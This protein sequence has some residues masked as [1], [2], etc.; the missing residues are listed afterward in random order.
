MTS[1]PTMGLASVSD[2]D[3][4]YNA[5][6]ATYTI[7]VPSGEIAIIWRPGFVNCWP[8]PSVNENLVTVSGGVD[9]LKLH[10]A[11][12]AVAKE[13]TA[14]L[15]NGRGLGVGCGAAAAGCAVNSNAPFNT[16][17]TSPMSR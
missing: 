2:I 3:R 10:A 9:D 14:R 1:A 13:G 12:P 6:L 8:W 17:C 4:R 16:S 5:W 7:C 15:H 11:M